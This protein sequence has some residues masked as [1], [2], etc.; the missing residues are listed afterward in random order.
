MA[1]FWMTFLFVACLASAA[2]FM[3]EGEE[4][5]S[6]VH[7]I[8]KRLK[9]STCKVTEMNWHLEGVRELISEASSSGKDVIKFSDRF[10][11]NGYTMRLRAK[12]ERIDGEL[13]LGLYLNPCEGPTDQLLAW[14]FRTPYTLTV[15]HPMEN[16][17]DVSKTVSSFSSTSADV[18]KRPTTGCNA[19]F[20]FSKVIRASEA[21]EQGYIFDNA[22]SVGVKLNL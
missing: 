5:S 15:F 13:W 11:L 6:T 1:F 20:G 9:R 22:I 21:E 4:S 12:V 8:L 3:G 17:L 18:F 19:A 16:T 2:D 7:T 10:V 14:P